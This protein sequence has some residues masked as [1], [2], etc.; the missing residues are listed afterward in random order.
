[1][2]QLV[3]DEPLVGRAVVD[4]HRELGAAALD[5][6]HVGEL[7]PAERAVEL[8]Q[9]GERRLGALDRD[10]AAPGL[11]VARLVEHVHRD[12][13]EPAALVPVRRV[14][15]H[16]EV[17]HP[18]RVPEEPLAAGLGAGAGVGRRACEAP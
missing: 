5:P 11:L 14:E 13:A 8:V 12:V 18:L 4:H 3:D 9:P 17:M 2:A 16:G 6:V 15:R 1:M 7:R 10:A